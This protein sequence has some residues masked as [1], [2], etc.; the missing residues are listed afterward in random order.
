MF[1]YGIAVRR[2]RRYQTFD[3]APLGKQAPQ[4]TGGFQRPQYHSRMRAP[5]GG[6]E[7]GPERLRLGTVRRQSLARRFE[8]PFRLRSRHDTVA[9]DKLEHAEHQ[10]WIACQLRRVAQKQPLARSREL[11]VGEP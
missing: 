9:A 3:G 8:P 6:S 5:E 7:R 1:A 11:L 10:R 4:Q 2:I